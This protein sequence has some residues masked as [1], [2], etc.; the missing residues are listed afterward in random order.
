MTLVHLDGK[1]AKIAIQQAAND[2]DQ[3]KRESFIT[4]SVVDVD[5]SSF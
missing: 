3:V 5:H 2:V 4:S 1:E